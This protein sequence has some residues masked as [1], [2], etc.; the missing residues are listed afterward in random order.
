MSHLEVKKFAI[1]YEPPTF[2]IQYQDT[3]NGKNFLKNI[4]LKK[5]A[6]VDSGKLTNKLIKENP[7]LLGPSKVHRDQILDLVKLIVE[8]CHVDNEKKSSQT[9][10]QLKMVEY[11]DLNKAS[12]VSICT[13]TSGIATFPSIYYQPHFVISLIINI[14][15]SRESQ[16]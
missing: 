11:G 7:D 16:I 5:V 8:H 2:I 10:V 12:D 13:S 1:K 15:C 9:A 4:R 3:S 6:G 14:G